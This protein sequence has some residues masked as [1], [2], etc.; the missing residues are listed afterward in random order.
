MLLLM[1][2]LQL[3]CYFMLRYI[4]IEIQSLFGQL[5][6]ALFSS[7]KQVKIQILVFTSEIKFDLTLNLKKIKFFVSFM[8]LVTILN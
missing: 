6:C 1:T 4:G 3:V 7:N 5:M 2:P 8:P